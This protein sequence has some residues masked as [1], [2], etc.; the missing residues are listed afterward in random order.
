MYDFGEYGEKLRYNL[1]ITIITVVV[2]QK[3]KTG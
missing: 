3:W 2:T 1:V